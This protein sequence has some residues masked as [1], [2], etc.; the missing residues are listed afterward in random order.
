MTLSDVAS[1]VGSTR[2]G[3]R[4]IT[5][6]LRANGSLIREGSTKSGKWIVVNKKLNNGKQEN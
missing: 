6:K 2:D 4:K 1:E 3:I 5:D